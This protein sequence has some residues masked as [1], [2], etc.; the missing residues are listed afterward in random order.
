[1]KERVNKGVNPRSRTVARVTQFPGAESAVSLTITA[2][3]IGPSNGKLHWARSY[4][5]VCTDSSPLLVPVCT[6][7]FELP[8]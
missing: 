7:L 2:D 5:I 8:V 6:I 3:N 4:F 1:M